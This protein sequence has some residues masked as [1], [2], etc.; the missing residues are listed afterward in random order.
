MARFGSHLPDTILVLVKFTIIR[1]DDGRRL[2][3]GHN[4]TSL[5][6]QLVAGFDFAAAR[7]RQADFWL[8]FAGHRVRFEFLLVGE[9]FTSA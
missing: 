9:S 6:F 1:T 3:A 5:C 8:V 4:A 2:E 7:R